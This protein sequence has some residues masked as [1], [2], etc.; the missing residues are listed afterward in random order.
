MRTKFR[1]AHEVKYRLSI[2]FEVIHGVLTEE[3]KVLKH[4]CSG[5]LIGI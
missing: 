3:R 1:V 4:A 2:V 5:E